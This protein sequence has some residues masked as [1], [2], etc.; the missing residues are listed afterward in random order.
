[1]AENSW[2]LMKMAGNGWALKK[3][4]NKAEIAEKLEMTGSSVLIGKPMVCVISAHLK[5]IESLD[6]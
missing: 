1:M 5:Y 3:W 4:M 2:N 6:T